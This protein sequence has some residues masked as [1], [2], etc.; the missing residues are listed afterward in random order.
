[1]CMCVF[2]RWMYVKKRSKKK[3]SVREAL[4]KR[5]KNDRLKFQSIISPRDDFCHLAD[6]RKGD[7]VGLLL[8]AF[9]VGGSTHT[10]DII[11]RD[12]ISH[13]IH[14]RAYAINHNAIAFGRGYFGSTSVAAVPM[15]EFRM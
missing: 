14:R 12:H 10:T 1:M 9:C 4:R 3:K 13:H 6:E 11:Y 8:G 7:A 5:K 2:V 15:L